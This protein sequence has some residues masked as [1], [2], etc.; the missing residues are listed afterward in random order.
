RRADRIPGSAP[1]C[2]GPDRACRDACPQPA[3]AKKHGR[4]WAPPRGRGIFSRSHGATLRRPL[5]RSFPA[6][7]KEAAMSSRRGSL[8]ARVMS[9]LNVG[10]PA[11]Q[12]ILMAEALKEKGWETLLITGEVSPG[13]GSMESAARGRHLLPVKIES[14][15]RE[16]SLRSD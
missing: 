14:L 16:V 2:S 9:R 3:S 5:P 12:A 6:A 13:E 8:I 10:G 7:R 4:A 11:R 15:G 1:G